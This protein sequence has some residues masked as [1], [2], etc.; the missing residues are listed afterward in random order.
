LRPA[1]GACRGL[2]A[3]GG[4]CAVRVCDARVCSSMVPC[5]SSMAWRGSTH[6]LPRTARSHHVDADTPRTERGGR[7]SPSHRLLT[8][9]HADPAVRTHGSTHAA[10][11]SFVG[12]RPTV[13]LRAWAAMW[14][15]FARDTCSTPRIWAFPL[16]TYI[17]LL[18]SA[19]VSGSFNAIPFNAMQCNAMQCNAMQCNAMQCNAM[20]PIHSFTSMHSFM[21]VAIYFGV[22]GHNLRETSHVLNL[23]QA[24]HSRLKG[25]V[26]YHRLLSV[27]IGYYQ[28]LCHEE[29]PFLYM[30]LARHVRCPRARWVQPS[31][32]AKAPRHR[33]PRRPD[34]L[35]I[36]S[37]S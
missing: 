26:G 12:D 18:L 36:R 8:T 20:H 37:S 6:A 1:M 19:E 4:P 7:G 5:C 34:Y 22:E 11:H 25:E 29:G 14:S 10:T 15:T 2:C 28:L 16:L 27:T 3:C 21:Q 31:G 23:L 33:T 17:V 24:Q 35:D 32:S 9:R 13:A 30:L